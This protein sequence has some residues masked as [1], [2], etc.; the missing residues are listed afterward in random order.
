MLRGG[1]AEALGI[2]NDENR[3]MM[4]E[5][6][7]KAIIEHLTSLGQYNGNSINNGFDVEGSTPDPCSICFEDFK[8]GQMLRE[9]NFC[10][11]MF[12]QACIEEWIK[13]KTPDNGVPNCPLCKHDLVLS[14]D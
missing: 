2:E 14:V 3:Q 6:K 1:I 8:S 9:I 11:H 4:F 13:R 5:A 12:H 10:K 7:S